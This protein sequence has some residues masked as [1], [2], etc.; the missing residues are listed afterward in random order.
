M[1]QGDRAAD[2]PW[3][4]AEAG[5]G[6]ALDPTWHGQGFG[7]EI[8]GALLSLTFDDVGLHRVTAGCFAGDIGSCRVMEKWGMRREQHGVQDSWHAEHGWVDGYTYALLRSEWEGSDAQSVSAG[9]GG[10]TS[11]TGMGQ[12]GWAHGIPTEGAGTTGTERL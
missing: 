1:G 8:V 2:S 6:Y 7:T 5:M 4:A 11:G 3:T 9:W 12:A 10:A